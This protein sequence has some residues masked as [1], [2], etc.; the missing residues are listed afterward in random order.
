[1]NELSQH[2]SACLLKLGRSDAGGTIKD[3]SAL[4]VRRGLTPFLPVIESFVKFGGYSLPFEI[5]GRFKVYRP[6]VAVQRMSSPCNDSKDPD[7]FRILFGE[8]ETTQSYYLMDGYGG[9]FED[10]RPIAENMVQW[11]EHWA[12]GN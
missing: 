1:M 6:K 5:E 4:F 7:Q 8:S 10:D 2:A 11:I 12:S 3:V 9:L